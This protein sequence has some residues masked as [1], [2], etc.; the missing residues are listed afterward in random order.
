M[1]SKQRVLIV[2]DAGSRDYK[3]LTGRG[4]EIFVLDISPQTDIANFY[5]QSITERTPFEDKFFDGVVIADVL[6]HLFED[7][8][9]LQE[10]WRILKDDGVLVVSVPYFSN[11]QDQ[12]PSHVRIHSRKTIEK[13]L[14]SCGFVIEEHFCRGLVSRLPQKSVL[15]RGMVYA[16]GLVLLVLFGER[17]AAIY[18]RLWY[19]TEKWIGSHPILSHVQKWFTS[20]GGIMKARKGE[21]VD[22]MKMQIGVFAYKSYE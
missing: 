15:T 5:L 3:L 21:A 6:E 8:M 14:R 2:G 13:L 7:R 22:Y 20:Y 12:E 17:G 16:T 10:L 19:T 9:A 4:K 11:Q 18:R 1:E